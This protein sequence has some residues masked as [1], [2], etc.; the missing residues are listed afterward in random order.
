MTFLSAMILYEALMF[1]Y[2]V[3]HFWWYIVLP[4]ESTDSLFLSV[5]STLQELW[6]GCQVEACSM[7]GLGYYWL[8]LVASS[9]M[10][11]TSFWRGTLWGKSVTDCSEGGGRTDM[12]ERRRMRGLFLMAT[13]RKYQSSELVSLGHRPPTSLSL[14]I[15]WYLSVSDSGL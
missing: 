14:L 4:R 8:C 12:L 2:F 6:W 7:L 13:W 11:C 3:F 9:A 10:D 5:W 1:C 15:D